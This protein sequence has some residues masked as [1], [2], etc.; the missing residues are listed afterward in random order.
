M[1]NPTRATRARPAKPRSA[2]EIR[3]GGRGG[4]AKP[5]PATNARSAPP[6]VSAPPPALSDAERVQLVRPFVQG[7]TFEID[8]ATT[9][10]LHGLAR[11]K[12]K[13]LWLRDKVQRAPGLA[14][15][16]E[17]SATVEFVRIKTPTVLDRVP[18]TSRLAALTIAGAATRDLEFL[19]G[20]P[21][22]ERLTLGD[23][24]TNLAS[25]AGIEACPG[26]TYVK[27]KQHLA[28][29]LQPLA[30]LRKL[31]V[32]VGP[33]AK[34][35][36]SLEGLSQPSLLL[37][38]VNLTPIQSLAPLASAR[39]LLALKARGAR[40][41]SLAP[42]LACRRLQTLYAER[43]ALASVEGLGAAL[44]DLRLLWIG[45][46]RVDQLAGL[47]GLTRLLELDLTGLKRVRD[48]GPLAGLTQ[49]RYLNL[50]DT[51]FADLDLLA[52]LPNLRQVRLGRTAVS[53]RDPRVKQLDAALKRRGGRAGGVRFEATSAA[54]SLGN[55]DAAYCS[56]AYDARSKH[57][58]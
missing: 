24:Q 7:D 27:A 53:P 8:R 35:L 41:T 9:P 4:G 44:R 12:V 43:S 52:A 26:L 16:L 55:R 42:I 50:F 28:R 32:F 30:A 57:N 56:L 40:F 33:T 47:A 22:L 18:R 54:T 51:G 34:R 2:A 3:A 10:A 11:T 21:K 58:G 38:D 23:R 48:F 39:G 13:H 15:V 17:A 5:R 19:R 46:T 29:S 1:R 14:D 37:V 31:E 25:F 20:F 6:R 45:D 49:L 36:T